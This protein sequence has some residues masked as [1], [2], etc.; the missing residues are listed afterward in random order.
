[1]DVRTFVLLAF[2]KPLSDSV[3]NAVTRKA[4]GRTDGQTDRQT[5]RQTLRDSIDRACIASRGKKHCEKSSIKL[6][7]NEST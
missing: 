1:M 7:L 2:E 6:A 4:D 5:D 3:D